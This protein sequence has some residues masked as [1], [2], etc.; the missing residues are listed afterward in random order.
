MKLFINLLNSFFLK[1]KINSNLI[2]FTQFILESK[3]TIKYTIV[4]QN[5]NKN[6]I[7]SKLIKKYQ[8]DINQYKLFEKEIKE[9]DV[10]ILFGILMYLN[11]TEQKLVFRKINNLYKDK[12]V[13]IIHDTTIKAQ[14]YIRTPFKSIGT[15]HL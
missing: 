2:L 10:I 7:K 4:D 9:A 12:A 11:K 3:N 15:G 14:K 5:I 13:I 6:L 8:T 1:F